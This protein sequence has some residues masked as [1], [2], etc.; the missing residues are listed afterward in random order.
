[1]KNEKTGTF[2]CVENVPCFEIQIVMTQVQKIKSYD[3][4]LIILQWAGS[5]ADQRA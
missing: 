1:M 2:I 4:S 3:I 5:R